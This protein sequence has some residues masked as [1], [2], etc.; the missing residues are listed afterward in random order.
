MEE[1]EVMKKKKANRK[2]VKFTERRR[3]AMDLVE[4]IDAHGGKLGAFR[5]YGVRPPTPPTTPPPAPRA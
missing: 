3:E 2:V 5:G 1:E 4:F